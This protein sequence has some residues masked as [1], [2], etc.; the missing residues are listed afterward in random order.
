MVR[1]TTDTGF[2]LGCKFQLV[3]LMAICFGGLPAMGAEH[4]IES[5]QVYARATV[6]HSELETLR[7]HLGKPEVS[8][9]V[10]TA[11]GVTPHET[12]FQAL[13]LFRNANQLCFEHTGRLAEVPPLPA[14]TIDCHEVQKVIDA[15]LE[16]IVLVRKTF[17]TADHLELAKDSTDTSKSRTDVFNLLV[18]SNRQLNLLLDRRVAP[19]EVFSQAT[20]ASSYTAC[21]LERSPEF[22]LLPKAPAY[23]AGKR[24][25][26][27]F[28]RLLI[29]LD[30]VRGIAQVSDVPMLDLTINQ[31]Q[32]STVEPSDVY[33]LASLIVA[34]L[35]CLHSQLEGAQSPP[36]LY[37]VGRK[38]P[39][40][41]Y[42]R[43]GL[44]QQQL[45]TLE[46]YVQLHPDWLSQ[47]TEQ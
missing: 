2:L 6:V 16:R 33:H 29:C 46:Q 38:V 4:H 30:H 26:D 43:V 41:V 35:T 8:P 14:G 3:G 18:Q 19:R 9:P 32:L 10:I 5:F 47:D 12:Y 20:L 15:A 28:H 22:D 36:D 11:S 37:E 34:E 25:V 40:D 44:L 17:D 39:S 1:E 27:V 24:P 7:Y 21:L 31:D 42:Q 23:E 13:A 45:I